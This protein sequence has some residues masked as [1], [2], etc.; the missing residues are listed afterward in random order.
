MNPKKKNII[1]KIVILSL[2]AVIIGLLV[3][4]LKD[5]FFPFIKMEIDGN[6]E[7]AKELLQNK[8]ILGYMTVSLV[9]ALQMVVIF[10]PA[11]FIQISSGMSY[12]WYLAVLLCDFGV[13]LGASIIYF[14]VHVFKFDGDIFKKGSK[15]GNYDNGDGSTKSIV[16]LM[17]FLFVMPIIPFGAIC[18]YASNKKIKYRHYILTVVTAVI[19]S[20]FTSIVMGAAVKE[21]ISNTLPIWL[22][23]L[24]IF[25][26]GAVLFIGIFLILNKFYFK[27]NDKTPDSIF[28]N[29]LTSFFRKK[30]HKKV[31][32]NIKGLDIKEL[33]TPYI[34]L[35]NHS[36][37]YDYYFIDKLGIKKHFNFICNRHYFGMPLL[38][39]LAERI[40]FIPKRIFAKDIDTIKGSLKAIKAGYPIMMFP[41]GRLSTDGTI[42]SINPAIARFIFKLNVPVVLVR[43]DN[44]YLAK[45]KWRKK[46]FKST[47]DVEVRDILSVDD[48]KNY[49]NDSLN[50]K[51]IEAL[52]SNP[53][54][55]NNQNIYNQKNKALRLENILYRCPNCKSLYKM[56]SHNNTL[57]CDNCGKEFN[58]DSHYHFD[59]EK[60]RDIALYQRALKEIEREEISSLSLEIPVKTKIFLPSK[61]PTRYKT[62][63]DEGVI[64]F[65][66]DKIIYQSDKTNYRIEIDNKDLEG[67]AY[68][69]GSEFE[70]YYQNNLHYFYPKD[71]KGIC[72]R[73]ALIYEILKEQE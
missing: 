25:A 5:I 30:M 24:I 26:A 48:L 34:L 50:Q 21:F 59:D 33:E 64:Y 66:K 2:A 11:E 35:A 57:K 36:C 70:F 51:I 62:K 46:I 56:S 10:I 49:D 53:Y 52:S 43:I 63:K 68:S 28:Y 20:I 60:I 42:Q 61:K 55:E 69:A 15:I 44:A 58:I 29:I 8:G 27:Q 12:P 72:A 41:E 17:Y 6:Q 47:V 3:F 13:F 7:G 18:Y 22:L 45:P 73:M 19:P 14:I 65:D 16:I 23:I 39:Y 67:I 4:F 1:E 32:V 38:G 40:G 71:N 54:S 31:K 37:Y 9:E